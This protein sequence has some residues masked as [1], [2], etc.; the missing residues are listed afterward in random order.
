M[1]V[2]L[3]FRFLDADCGPSLVHGGSPWPEKSLSFRY[4]IVSRMMEALSNCDV[5]AAGRGSIL[6]SS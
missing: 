6:A 5:I 3:P 4:D 1:S 2:T